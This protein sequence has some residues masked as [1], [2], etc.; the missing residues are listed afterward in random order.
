MKLNT[1]TES[2]P[3]LAIDFFSDTFNVW[4]YINWKWLN[5][6]MPQMQLYS[7]LYPS[8]QSQWSLHPKPGKEH[9]IQ[10]VEQ[11]YEASTIQ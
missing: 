1:Y 5:D 2:N 3:N 7:P 4:Y 8:W 6:L 9:R 11:E 10:N